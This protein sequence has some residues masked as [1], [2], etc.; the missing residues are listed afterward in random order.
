[1]A[2][3]HVHVCRKCPTVSDACVPGRDTNGTLHTAWSVPTRSEYMTGGR[4]DS[5]SK[6]P[7]RYLSMYRFIGRSATELQA[8]LV[9][10]FGTQPGGSIPTVPTCCRRRYCVGS[11][12][13]DVC[14]DRCRPATHGANMCRP[15][16]SGPEVARRGTPRAA[17]LCW[18]QICSS[19]IFPKISHDF[20]RLLY[21]R[22]DKKRSISQTVL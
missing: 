13:T 8:E 5:V 12:R 22:T 6:R 2:H 21:I 1:M 17:R 9:P 20:V 7:S 4:T 15:G 11:A 18:Y 10:A 3:N 19:G 16:P 14:A